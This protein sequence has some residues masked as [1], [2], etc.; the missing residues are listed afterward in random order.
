MTNWFFVHK[1][2]ESGFSKAYNLIVNCLIKRCNFD[3]LEGYVKRILDIHKNQ[4]KTECF[5]VQREN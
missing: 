3:D 2:F 1:S 4:S 5:V